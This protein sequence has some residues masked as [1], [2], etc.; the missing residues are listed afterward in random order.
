MIEYVDGNDRTIEFS[1]G[2]TNFGVVASGIAKGVCFTKKKVW[3]KKKPIIKEIK[4][5]L[6]EQ[7]KKMLL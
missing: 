3:Y 4:M 6:P 7:I 2:G 5:E 1:L